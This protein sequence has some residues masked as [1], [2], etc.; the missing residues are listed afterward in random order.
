MQ[1]VYIVGAARTPVGR[2][3]GTLKDTSVSELGRVGI[4]A[5]LQRSNIDARHVDEVIMGVA[6]PSDEPGGNPA[7]LAA[8]K[9]GIPI[10]A[11]AFS[12]N[13]NCISGLRSVS[14]A[15][16]QISNGD[17]EAIIAGGM[18][19]MSQVPYISS[20]TRWGKKLGHADLLDFLRVA[21][22]DP[23]S[24]LHMGETAEKLV[25]V[26][27]IS[28]EEQDEW[29]LMSQQRAEK[30]INS[31]YFKEEITP[32]TIVTRKGEQEFIQDEHPIFGVSP[33]SLAKLKPAFREGGSVTPGNSSG[34]NDAGAAVVLASKSKME[35]CDAKP[36]AKIV[37]YA[38]V[39]VK[40]ELMGIA[41]AYAI[42]NIL[43]NTKMSLTDIDL[44]ECNEAFAAQVIAVERE[45]KW[46]R[47]KVN[48]N[49]GAIA[50]GHPIGASGTR[51]LITLMYALRRINKQYG[52][53]ALCCGGGLGGA[54]LIENVS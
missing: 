26:Y 10:E 46:D 22:F 53:A 15:A 50:L 13:K 7:R 11:P 8:V 34:L 35:E 14:L 28:R 51:V 44:F 43:N 12:I 39:G 3:G 29:A 16:S 27:S 31:G 6:F 21:M 20:G 19:N 18:E 37:A 41:P 52:I 38:S 42:K 2:F 30:A 47:E 17:A 25:D 33:E 49:G 4:A 40:P 1:E 32:V 23:L 9:A 48:I 54:I 45:L 36:L 5:S 24:G